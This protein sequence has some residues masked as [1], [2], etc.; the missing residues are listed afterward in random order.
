[1][2]LFGKSKAPDPKEQVNYNTTFVLDNNDTF[3]FMKYI[4]LDSL[5][6]IV[7]KLNVDLFI[8]L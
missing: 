3:Y 5:A 7:D 1:M 4:V 8:S 6:C 2:G